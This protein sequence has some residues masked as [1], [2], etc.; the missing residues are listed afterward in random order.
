MDHL[1]AVGGTMGFV[2]F[3]AVFGGTTTGTGPNA[4]G[5]GMDGTE[6]ED[7]VPVGRPEWEWEGWSVG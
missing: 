1:P 2:E 3:G 6:C 5:L 7:S 4:I